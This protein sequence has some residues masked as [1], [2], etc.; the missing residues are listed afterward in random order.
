MWP[1]FAFFKPFFKTGYRIE[2]ESNELKGDN[3]LNH[4]IVTYPAVFKPLGNDIYVIS[5]PDIGGA[6][7][8]GKGLKEAMKMAADTLASRLYNRRKLPAPSDPNDIK[9][10]DQ[11]FVVK[12]SADLTEASQDRIDYQI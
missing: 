5:F 6:I 4:R 3:R 11:A 10:P 7:T 8:E 2:R 9:A 12:V 1:I